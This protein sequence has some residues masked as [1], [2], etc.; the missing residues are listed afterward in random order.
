MHKNTKNH[1]LQVFQSKDGKWTCIQQ[2][3]PT[4][5]GK[6][7]EFID[8]IIQFASK[9]KQV[10]IL[11]SMDASR[12]L[13]SQI[14]GPPFRVLGDESDEY[15]V[16]SKA[17]GIP[18][19]EKIETDEK[20]EHHKLHLPGSGLARQLY[21]QLK[22][23][24]T[25][26]LLIMFALEGGKNIGAYIYAHVLNL[27][28]YYDKIDNVQDSIEFA[29]YVNTLLTIQTDIKGWTPPKSWEFLFGTPF[30]AELYQ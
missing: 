4:L 25:T 27:T 1:F 12:R 5:K 23:Q 6:R 9:F 18:V 17:L 15:V 13:D 22:D 16:K 2:R 28:N 10:V 26:T 11:T 29:N 3:S 19:L 14:N 8:N 7:Q 20:E 24:V 21:E 30:N